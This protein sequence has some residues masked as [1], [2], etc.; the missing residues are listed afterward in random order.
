MTTSKLCLSL[1]LTCFLYVLQAQTCEITSVTATPLACNGYN[2]LVSV[3]LEVDNPASPGFK[4]AGNGEIY[5]TFLYEDLPITVGPFLGDDETVYEF[6]AWDVADPGCQ[7]F[8]SIPAANCG[9]ICSISDFNLEFLTCVG[10]NS[11]LIVFDFEYENPPSNAFTLYNAAG[12]EIGSYLYTSLPITEPFFVFNGA[13]PI[14]LTVC[15]QENDFCC[16]TFTVDAIDCNPNNCEIFSVVADPEC[17]GNNFLV[18]LNFGYDNPPS[19]SFSVTGNSINY[20]TFGYN[21]LPVS[22]GPLNGNTGIQWEFNITDSGSDCSASI[23]LGVYTCPPPCDVL[24]L[25]AMAL[26]CFGNEAYALEVGLEIE[27]EGDLGFAIFSENMYYGSYDYEEVP[28]TVPEFEGSGEFIDI[29]SVCDNENLG[30]CATTPFEALLCAGCL[31]YNLTATALPC[32]D[33]GEIFVE[34]NFDYQNVS[35]VGFEITGNGDNYGEFQYED[36]PVQ[37]GPFVGDGS[38]YFE[39]VVTDLEDDLCFEAVELGF[40]DCTEICELTNLTVETG[41]CTGPDQYVAVI[42]FDVQ[43]ASDGFDLFINGEFYNDYPY[44]A[45]PLTIE[46]FPSSGTGE[47]LITVCDQEDDQCCATLEFEAPD[48][49]C[50]IFDVTYQTLD[51][52]NDSEFNISLEFFYENLPSN[53]VD[54]FL[55]GDPLGFFNVENQPLILTIPEGDGSAVLSI[56]ANDLSTCCEEILI[57]LINCESPACDI[58]EFFAEAGDCTSDSTFIVDLVFDYE[59]FP[60]DSI[61]VTA[62]NEFVGQYLIQPNFNHIENFPMLDAD[63]TVITICAVGAPDCCASYSIVTP[64]CSFFGQCHIFEVAADVGECTSDSTYNLHLHYEYQNLPVDSVIITANGNELGQFPATEDVFIIEDVLVYGTDLTTITICAV[65]APDC[66]GSVQYATP[67]C[68]D[69]GICEIWDLVAEAGECTSDSTYN[70]WVDFNSQYLPVDSVVVSVNGNEMGQFLATSEA[71]LVANVPV[72]DTEF[73]LITVCAVGSPD[74]CA[75]DEIV[76]PDCSNFGQCNIWDLVSDVGECTSDS[77]YNLH[78]NYNYQNLPSDSVIISFN[79]NEFGQFPAEDGVFL[80]QNVP[81]GDDDITVISVCAVGAPDCCDFD[82]YFTPNCAGGNECHIFD[83]VADP[84][85]CNDNQTYPLFIHYFSNNL[86]SDSVEVTANGNFI[87]VFLHNP[88]GFTIDEFPA[89]NITPTTITVCA[90]GAPDCCDTFTFETPDCGQGFSCNLYDLFAE[91]GGCTSDSTF[92]L[93]V[94]FESN[95]TPNDSVLIYAN[96]LLVGTF[97]N[98]PN[99]IHIENFPEMGTDITT[100]TVCAQDAPDCCDTYSIETPFCTDDCVIYDVSVNVFDC[101]TDSTF[102]IVVDFES[103]N[104]PSGGFDIYSGDIYLGFFGFDNVPAEIPN[105]PANET[106]QYVVTICES[107]GLECCTSFEFEGPTCEGGGGCEI[108]NLEWTISPCSLAC[109]FPP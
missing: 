47:D 46:E 104:I 2:F 40:I 17:T 15:D 106:G 20:G 71:I 88:D 109:G 76:T 42:D 72:Y 66:C 55:N 19:D 16:E 68:S 49:A 57:E 11:G 86:P 9:P 51:C 100:V 54:I 96:D 28:V 84:G 73:S 61:T 107:D 52:I 108:F 24:A 36:L 30:C 13:A 87:G 69:F 91:I 83:L 102:A 80:L 60:T 90:V 79:G 25:E 85:V 97:F 53:S 81:V 37:I 105:F 27:G 99:F 7:N 78:I 14:V 22:L 50:D 77:T 62:N 74:C 67:D 56:C 34:I 38:Q 58:T 43:A 8:T 75:T 41:E 6:I 31:I 18:H 26:E 64:D 44:T 12:V 89:Y 23:L 65:D 63:T 93:D 94:V 98:E 5:G 103:Q 29:V 101:N 32:N 92:I 70:L 21:E 35:T 1:L 48:C 4:L 82:E 45:L 39:F 10:P 95:H 3:D 59:N 33:Q